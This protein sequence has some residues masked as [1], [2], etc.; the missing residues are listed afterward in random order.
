MN[1]Y[2]RSFPGV[3][4][5][6]ALSCPIATATTLISQAAFHG[7]SQATYHHSWWAGGH[8]DIW[9]PDIFADFVNQYSCCPAEGYQ[10]WT[11][12]WLQ[13]P[14]PTL[15][16]HLS[17]ATLYFNVGGYS[18]DYPG[19]SY[20]AVLGHVTDSS[21]ATGD[22]RQRLSGDAPAANLVPYG[23]GWY[24]VNVTAA[25][26]QDYAAHHTWSAFQ[27]S[28]AAINNNFNSTFHFSTVGS[29]A[30]YLRIVDIDYAPEPV[31]MLLC[32]IGLLAL[33][34]FKYRHDQSKV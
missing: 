1:L 3:A 18:N 7:S 15:I 12:S 30:P 25:I 6:F 22:A 27:V 23:L 8:E 20:A 2:H 31:S 10:G 19:R 11:Y 34:G 5:V 17:T 9:G 29:S 33:A 26:A 14:L 4:L 24:G 16:G 32:G 21:S 13:I 28:P